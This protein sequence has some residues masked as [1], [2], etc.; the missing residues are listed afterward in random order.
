[1]RLTI[2]RV[3]YTALIFLAFIFLLFLQV[4]G[5]IYTLGILAYLVYYE[6][7][8]G[9]NTISALHLFVFLFIWDLA[10]ST[11]FMLTFLH[12]VYLTLWVFIDILVFSLV[13][14]GIF[15]LDDYLATNVYIEDKKM[16]YLFRVSVF[17]AVYLF[18]SLLGI[19]LPSSPY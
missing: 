17:V 18:I 13:V 1:M 2:G 11:A 15:A 7:K 16:T 14:V 5:A 4:G 12:A 6:H 9:N 8:S 10:L 3:E 19:Y